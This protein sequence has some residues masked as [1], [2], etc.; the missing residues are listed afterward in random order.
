[1]DIKIISFGFDIENL[2]CEG[3][4]LT[5]HKSTRKGILSDHSKV[6]MLES[7]NDLESTRK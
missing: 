3:D 4:L 1:M 5:Q 7:T 6:I 2:D